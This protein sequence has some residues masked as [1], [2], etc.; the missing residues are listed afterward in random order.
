MKYSTAWWGATALVLAAVA[1]CGSDSNGGSTPPPNTQV[2]GAISAAAVVPA[3]DSA[4]NPFAPF[5][6]LQGAGLP[7]VTVASPPKL[8]F[9]VFS[10]GAVKTGLTLADMSFAIA[11]L[12]PGTNGNPDEWQNYVSR[13]ATATAAGSPGAAK[14][15][16]ATAMQATTD[17]K[18][19]P[20]E[21]AAAGLGPQLVYNDAGYYTYTFS[22]DITDPAWSATINKVAYSTNGVVFDPNAT[23][24]VAIQLSYTNAAG[25]VIR[26]NPHFSFRF[27]QNA[28]GGYDSV[29]LTDPAT[30]DYLMADVSSCNACHEKL[31]LHGGGRVDVQYCV[32]CHNPGTTDPD[33]GN[34]L[35]LSTMA[36]KIHAG[37][38]LAGSPG[39]ENYTIW[40]YNNVKYDYS[41]IG[42]PQALQNCAKCH[43]AQNPSTPQGD[44]WKSVPSQEAC[45][46][47]HASNA[48]STW[49]ASHLPF[50]RALYGPTANAKALSNADCAGCH[51][52][53]GNLG[54]DTVHWN[55]IEANSALYKMNI[56][57]TTFNDTADHKGRTVTVKYF[58]SNPTADNAAYNLVTADCTGTA[59][60]P[61]CSSSTK[62]GNLRFY[63]AYQ[64][65]AGQSV[66]VTEFTSYNNGGG[67]A[68]A[69]A[70]KGA[71]DGSNHYTVAIPL[72]DDVPPN[73]VA[74]GTAQVASAGQVK[75]PTQNLMSVANPR[76]PAVPASLTSVVV[77][78]TSTE[79]ALSGTLQPRRVIVAND[80]CNVCH[81]ALG[82]TSG[83]NTL[84]NAFHG[85]S[86]DTVQVCVTCHDVNKTSSGTVMASGLSFQESYQ[87]KR[88]IHGIHGNSKRQFPFTN[89]NKVIG[90]FDKGSVGV[91]AKLTTPGVVG[92]DYKASTAADC[93]YPAAISGAA[94]AAGTPLLCSAINYAAEVFWPANGVN[95]NACHVNN[96]Y[97]NDQGPLG[98]VVLDRSALGVPGTP[99]PIA[100]AWQRFVISPKAA[101]CTACHDSPKAIGHV[102]SFG[103]ATYGNLAQN[104]WPQETCADC[105]SGGMFMGVDRVHGLK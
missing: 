43:T 79:L 99:V 29:L 58:L 32:M 67:S 4:L 73:I 14:T 51:F 101:S 26:V 57:S 34:V 69:Y 13:K 24:R 104:A 89:G 71:N 55:Q 28:A 16:P 53:G 8:N 97:Q 87:F 41:E 35:T 75:E 88:M 63:L 83:S 39:G 93:S 60:A 95:C 21:L 77:Q 1:G 50:A 30:Q 74:S 91:P 22:A 62:F 54:S 86:R 15:P 40:G 68:N 90:S 33:S 44:N 59:A 65:M 23:H 5:T 45:L 105:H 19:T 20:D 78:H 17:P 64:N 56:E 18:R 6:V 48:G 85:G 81:G 49:E 82:S 94:V 11:K 102:T 27:V 7:A 98:A 70:Y 38:G 100:D 96:S 9:T 36:H 10:D 72:P 84:A 80:K 92:V 52:A 61:V 31:A 3:N 76:P 37:R 103:N 46:T 47:C 2:A 42:Y 25:E 66:G 12:V